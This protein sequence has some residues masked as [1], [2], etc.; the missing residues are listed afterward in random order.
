VDG[1]DCR[2]AEDLAI[3]GGDCGDGKTRPQPSGS[4]NVS[5]RD[6]CGF[7]KFHSPHSFEV[8]AAHE[9]GT[10]NSCSD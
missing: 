7:H 9:A 8:H 1:I 5:A 6:G 2:I 4:L 3:I 10:E